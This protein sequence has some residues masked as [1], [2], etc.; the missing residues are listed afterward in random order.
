MT[1][2]E[3]AMEGNT[4]F[5]KIISEFIEKR[6]L[7]DAF[8]KK[9]ETIIKELLNEEHFSIHEI[10]SRTKEIDSF[11]DKVKKEEKF[12]D[13]LSDVTDLS[14]VRIICYFSDDVD[15]AAAIIRE[16]FKVNYEKSIDKRK[17]LEP[18][19]FGYLS[20]H[21]IVEF[22]DERLIL[23]ECKKYKELMCEIQIRS[24][25]QHAWAEIEHDFGYKSS[26][27]IPKEIRRQFSRQAGLLELADEQ[28][29]AIKNDI[30]D[31]TNSVKSVIERTYANILI[32]DISM[33][34]YLDSSQTIKRID[35]IMGIDPSGTQEKANLIEYDVEIC[36]YFKISTLDNLENIL[37]ENEEKLI[38]FMKQF[39]T[40]KYSR[41]HPI[42]FLGYLLA[43][44]NENLVEIKNYVVSQEIYAKSE[45]EQE[46]L[47]NKILTIYKNIE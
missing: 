23:P 13:K 15:K 30:R 22:S 45:D 25:L 40:S 19:Q 39:L 12:Y 24:I 36:Q 33:K 21:Y 32:D 14:G 26:I 27:G 17:L 10:S 7:Y 8:T 47:V 31:Y 44:K 2:Q 5:S 11:S 41:G 16:N 3:D 42:W 9:T 20:L 28:F 38:K 43:A 35:S 29:V 4:D 37:K 18:D 46:K 6:P 34:T 1:V